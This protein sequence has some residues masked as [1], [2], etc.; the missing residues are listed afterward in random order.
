[1]TILDYLNRLNDEP[2]RPDSTVTLYTA[3]LSESVKDRDV[4]FSHNLHY[5]IQIWNRYLYSFE[6]MRFSAT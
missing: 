5:A 3:Y 6:I 1:M 4:K 2:D